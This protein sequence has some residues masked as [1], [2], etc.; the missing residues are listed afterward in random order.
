ML[1]DRLPKQERKVIAEVL[2]VDWTGAQLQSLGVLG[3]DT[4]EE[5]VLLVLNDTRLQQLHCR[6]F[7]S[8]G[9]VRHFRDL[10]STVE[11]NT[12]V[13]RQAA[14]VL[15]NYSIQGTQV[16]FGTVERLVQVWHTLQLISG[17]R[18][19]FIL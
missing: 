3:L 2:K 6:D 17:L 5:H 8:G 16:V 13:A 10:D 18:H 19:L 11:Y 4:V 14:V 15:L 9:K 12:T 1:Q 7:C